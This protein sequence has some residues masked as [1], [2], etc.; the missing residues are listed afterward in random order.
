M[1]VKLSLL[2]TGPDPENPIGTFAG[3]QETGAKVTVSKMLAAARL[4]AQ[5]IADVLR[6]SPGVHGV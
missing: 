6:G 1:A 3:K 4:I 5:E 2:P